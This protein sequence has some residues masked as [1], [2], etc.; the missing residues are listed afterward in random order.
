MTR[1]I[2]PWLLSI[3]ILGAFA[4]TLVFLY[5]KSKEEPQV[6]K[7]ASAERRSIVQKTVAA[8]AIVPRREVSIKPRVSGIVQRLAVVPGQ[9]IR[10]GDVIAEIKI[11]PNVVNLNTAEGRLASAEISVKTRKRE[12]QRLRELKLQNLVAEADF[13]R[14]E[15]EYQLAEQELSAAGNNLQLIKEGAIRGSGKVSNV[16]TS[17][18][19]GMV[20]D[21]PVKTG[22]SVIESNNFNEGTTIASVAD[23]KDMIFQGFV[24]ESEVGRLVEGMTASIAIGALIGQKFEGKLEY[25]S[26]KGATREGT[27]EFEVRAALLIPPGSF[28]RA[29]YSANAD[30]ILARRDSVLA[31]NERLLQFE[32]GRPYVEVQS[33]PQRYERRA[34]KLGLSDGIT[35]EVLEGLTLEDR[36]KVPMAVSAPPR[37]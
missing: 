20:I 22:G 34:L 23:M 28:V 7:T 35:V 11:V 10:G 25:I 32:S 27:I 4:W 21:V 16:V 36:I 18:V 15:L 6:F 14:S 2:L 9:L 29:N 26:P 30:I 19:A 13:N 12:Y 37:G 24:D 8:G 1:R 33:A 3:T 5:Q 31:I 17:T